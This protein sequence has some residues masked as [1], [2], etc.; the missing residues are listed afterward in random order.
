M[1]AVTDRPVIDVTMPG[2]AIANIL[3]RAFEGERTHTWLAGCILD[4]RMPRRTPWY[5]DASLFECADFMVWVDVRLDPSRDESE[6]RQFT[7]RI[8]LQ[9]LAE[10]RAAHP[11]LYDVLRAAEHAQDNC[12]IEEKDADAIVQLLFLGAIVFCDKGA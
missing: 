8:M 1:L 9:A 5:W 7:R 2:R 6:V 10:M 3:T 4:T 12:D 11:R